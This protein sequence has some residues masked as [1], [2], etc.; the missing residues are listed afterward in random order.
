M[1]CLATV[2]K[3]DVIKGIRRNLKEKE[4]RLC[5]KE[6]TKKEQKGDD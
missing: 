1:K 2:N 5:D 6:I 3:I 4:V